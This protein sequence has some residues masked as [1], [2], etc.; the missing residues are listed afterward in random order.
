MGDGRCFFVQ[1]LLYIF[2]REGNVSRIRGINYKV[3]RISVSCKLFL[4]LHP[5]LVQRTHQVPF[6]LRLAFVFCFLLFLE[7]SLKFSI[8]LILQIICFSHHIVKLKQVT[9]SVKSYVAVLYCFLFLQYGVCE[10]IFHYFNFHCL[11]CPSP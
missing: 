7:T 11:Y 4:M 8:H 6:I 5:G 10:Y 9:M 1:T 2:C 3:T